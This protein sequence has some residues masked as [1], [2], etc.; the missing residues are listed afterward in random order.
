M[1]PPALEK[2]W[3]RRSLEAQRFQAGGNLL[4]QRWQLII[5]ELRRLLLNLLGSWN[6]LNG[7]TTEQGINTLV[8]GAKHRA[9]NT[10]IVRYF[11]RYKTDA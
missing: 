9:S 3:S 5:Q 8:L 7:S 11:I 1:W 10:F 4:S 6:L 2:E